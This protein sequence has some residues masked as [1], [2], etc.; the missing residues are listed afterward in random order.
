ML[1]HANNCNVGNPCWFQPSL[2]V[3]RTASIT[4]LRHDG[5]GINSMRAYP[6]SGIEFLCAQA[7]FVQGEQRLEDYSRIRVRCSLYFRA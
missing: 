7:P 5:I 4:V 6:R 2:I 1:G 3:P